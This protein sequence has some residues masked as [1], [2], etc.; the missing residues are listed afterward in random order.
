MSHRK[1]IGILW[2]ETGFSRKDFSLSLVPQFH[3]G[4][5]SEEKNM[6]D[7]TKAIRNTY[8]TLKRS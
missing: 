3:D 2:L 8:H 4:R 6:G 5:G 1:S 7:F